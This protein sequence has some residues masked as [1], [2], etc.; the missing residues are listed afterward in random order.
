MEHVEQP[1]PCAAYV[2]Q[3]RAADPEGLTLGPPSHR[4]NRAAMLTDSRIRT[5]EPKAKAYKI[6]DARGLFVLV[7][8]NGTKLFQYD[9]RFE[10]KR[11]TYSLGV[12]PITTLKAAR[13][14]H[15]RVWKL[16]KAGTDPNEQKRLGRLVPA[17]ADSFES[18][19][20]DWLEKMTPT[21][22]RTHAEA[23]RTRF[24]K[25][26][27]PDL[28][29]MRMDDITAPI[30]LAVLQKIEKRGA[31]Y[32]VKR[33][34]EMTGTLFRFG[35]RTG[36]ATRDPSVE[37]H[38]AFV[39][40]VEKH[41]AAIVDP[42]GV[43]E[44]LRAIWNYEGSFTVRQAFRLTALLALRPGEIRK[45]EWAEV[46]FE[47]REIR[48]PA[49]KMKMRSPHIVP[50]SPQAVAILEETQEVT[51]RGRY[52]LPSARNP[53]G[54]RPMSE[55][56]VTA[57]LNRLGY[58]GQQSAHGFRSV[59]CSLLNEVGHFNPDAIERQLAHAER[60]KVRAAYLHG[61]YLAERRRMMDWWS[62]YCDELRT[63]QPRRDNV[64]KFPG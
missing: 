28:G 64:L 31:L 39:G 19:F 35:I 42:A 60:D 49:E 46:N 56:A 44:L 24:E 55:A 37:L 21:W 29:R 51:G 10:G 18:V 54:D 11:K 36:R 45:L 1:F 3:S 47:A 50:L 16:V 13:E 40:H 12:Y 7:K 53:R 61:Q 57:A 2:V 22:S 38:G 8:P 6:A 63:G 34:R 59:F 15:E 5:A 58:Q 17:G 41:R 25:D 32:L 20:R 43:A 62:N 14:E 4:R 33:A 9:Y 26:L 30:L 48:I 27:L 52:V 23:I